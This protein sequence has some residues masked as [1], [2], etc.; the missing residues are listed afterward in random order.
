MADEPKSPD[1]RKREEAE[2]KARD[3]KRRKAEEDRKRKLEEERKAEEKKAQ[4]EKLRRLEEERR[5][6]KAEEEAKRMGSDKIVELPPPPPSLLNDND[7]L[8]MKAW[9]VDDEVA[10]AQLR[11]ASLKPGKKPDAPRMT[12]AQLKELG[13]SYYRI[14]LN[15]FF[16]LNCFVKERKY[17]HLDEIRVSQTC[18]DEAFLEKWYQEH[19]NEDE[20]LRLVTDGSCYVDI[21]SKSDTW[22]RM[23]MQAG[24]CICLPAGLYH[25]ATLDEDDFCSVLRLFRDAQ[26]WTPVFRSEKKAENHPARALYTKQLKKG[27]VAREMDPE[28]K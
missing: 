20:Q 12:L 2:I 5:K 8:S 9:H 14:N 6:L 11:M 15:D 16:H 25:R 7:E 1:A 21:R 28:V 4:Q 22:V 17:K 26:R 23:H 10:K 3:E 24:D 19:F 13:V 18:K 27:N